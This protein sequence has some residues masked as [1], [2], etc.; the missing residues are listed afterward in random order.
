MLKNLNDKKKNV[1]IQHTYTLCG[2]WQFFGCCRLLVD[3]HDT[4]PS[5][6]R[7]VYKNK[8][9]WKAEHK[10]SMMWVRKWKIYSHTSSHEIIFFFLLNCWALSRI[11][12]GQNYNDTRMNI[13]T[14]K[15]KIINL[16]TYIWKKEC[17]FCMMLQLKSS[18]ASNWLIFVFTFH[19][20][21]SICP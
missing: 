11:F 1:H 9:K 16:S 6:I 12:S 4:R 10:Q 21:C 14:F 19:V 3:I 5:D 18:L 20:R 13:S 2:W 7:F 15:I 8:Q 17:D